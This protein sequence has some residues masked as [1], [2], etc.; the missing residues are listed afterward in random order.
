[1]LT[2]ELIIMLIPLL[3]LQLSLM[4]YCILKIIKEGVSM[5]S[6]NL[7]LFIVIAFNL[8]GPLLY[9]LIGRNKNVDDKRF[10]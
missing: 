9:L 3:I 2:K 7:W 10:E 1:M 5:G 6:K 4:I 8:V